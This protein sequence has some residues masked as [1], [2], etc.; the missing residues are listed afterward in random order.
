MPNTPLPRIDVPARLSDLLSRWKSLPHDERVQQAVALGQK[1]KKDA[2]AQKLLTELW[3]GEPYERRLAL[4]ACMGS[5]DGVRVLAAITDGSRLVRGQARKL[6][7]QC[8]DDA[9]ALQALKEAYTV[10]QHDAILVQL[11]ARGRSAPIDALLD[12]LAA[13]PEDTRLADLVPL[14][15]E[16]AIERH[17]ERA[18][19]RPSERFW[20]RMLAYRPQRLAAIL[21]SHLETQGPDSVWRH[22][23]W[24]SLQRLAVSA[25][26]EAL[27]LIDRILARKIAVDA[28][29]WPALIL[30]RPAGA[31]DLVLA[32]KVE[33]PSGSF[34]RAAAELGATR[35]VGLLGQARL[36]LG[37]PKRWWKKI[38]KPDQEAVLRGF[39]VNLKQHPGWGPDLLRHL[40]GELLAERERAYLAWSF[41]ARDADGVIARDN[42][43]RLPPELR[44]R[45]ARRHL[46]EVTQLQT[47]PAE[48]IP[49]ALYLPWEEAQA[50][51]KVYLGHP[52]GD[53][54]GRTLSVLLQIPGLWPERTELVAE[55]LRMCRAR[56]NEQDPVRLAMF[57]ALEKWPRHIWKPGHLADFGQLLR[58]GLDA[59]DL[60]HPTAQAMERVLIRVF[61]VDGSFGAKWLATLVKE[62]GALYSPR[63]G[64]QLSDDDVRAAA[65]PLMEVAK[66]WAVREREGYLVALAASL[67][68]RIGLVADGRGET[69]WALLEKTMRGTANGGTAGGILTL[70]WHYQRPRC[71]K[72]L[73]E[74]A[75]YLLKRDWD[76][77][78]IGVLR[79]MTQK[80][81][82]SAKL[83]K[84]ELPE[85]L[86]EILQDAVL[87]ARYP[88]NAA[89]L[90]DA[91]KRLSGRSFAE[92][93]PRAIRE[94]ASYICVDLVWQ[95]L[96]RRRQ[97]LLD[98]YLGGER[99]RGKF[100]TGKTAWVLPFY[101]GLFRWTPHQQ[102]L[103]SRSLSL[104]TADKDRD[105][106][107][108]FWAMERLV[109]LAF[110][111]AE[112][113]VVLADDTR[114]A[115]QERA[116]RT[117]ARFDAGQGVPKLLACLEDAR[118]RIAIYGL[119]RALFDMPPTQAVRI[120]RTVPLQKI[121]VAK[122]VFRLLGE[123]R[124]DEAYTFLIG[125]DNDG[126]HIDVRIALCRAL[127]DH[128]E[129]EQTWQVYHR[130][131]AGPSWIL[132]SRVGDIP[133]DRLTPA[134]D[135]RLSQLLARVLA[136]PEPEAR[137]E[138]L[139]RAAALPVKDRE[140][141]FYAA[142]LGRLDS[143][144]DDEVQAAIGAA[145]ARAHT[146]DVPRFEAALDALRPNR[147]ALRQAV[148]QLSALYQKG[149]AL[150]TRL[151]LVTR[152]VLLRDAR[153][154]PLYFSLL[155]RVASPDE[156]GAALCDLAGRGTLHTQ[157]LLAAQATVRAVPAHEAEGLE[158]RLARADHEALRWLAVS[159]LEVASG[160]GR[161]WTPARRERLLAYQ[162]DPSL[163]VSGAAQLVFPPEEEPPVQTRPAS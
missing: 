57:Q 51:L 99:V 49:Y 126:L 62:R 112:A 86:L 18:L 154:L 88:G 59:A 101:E 102:Q 6:V 153:L 139:R 98:P 93:V 23:I 119:R 127:W 146:E 85:E 152:D 71:L 69:L 48:R 114:P 128:L 56:K 138:L 15:S 37:D 3:L 129:R 148:A 137:L 124:A 30:R 26:D 122:E 22:V 72:I 50:Q 96:H 46:S 133:P 142:C 25:P 52:E 159:A 131:V 27:A 31:C 163:L 13:R 60:S 41:A 28:A 156:I 160:P 78:L 155:Q 7:P 58:D 140:R 144:Y 67:R 87:R 105:T 65:G 89:A 134:I 61:H 81:H 29:V 125:L 16:P 70:M 120:L 113:V 76:S 20:S 17:L 141:A 40:D 95:Y 19:Q 47:R 79:A 73:P 161:G 1:S 121:T 91:L 10:R 32:H 12:W 92:V 14:A 130:A 54:R 147:R 162:R 35:L 75:K 150:R 74:I 83:E 90:L 9:Q 145:V 100:A 45:E 109:R 117:L 80:A 123:L 34:E 116:L 118:A 38:A 63:L 66:A 39:F 108:V 143:R 107:G 103:F 55:A 2:R 157:G 5:D 4:K 36:L 149:D 24:L 94:D 110:A 64:D 53:V 77:V 151:V 82:A 106:P 33:L 8:C 158:A 132:A 43:H 44:A 42:V 68:E 21:R 115:V 104:V 11:R 135:L 84:V 111:P 136:R 97:D